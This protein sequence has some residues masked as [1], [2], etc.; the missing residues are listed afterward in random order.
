MFCTA[1]L[2]AGV[3]AGAS[4]EYLVDTGAPLGPF[5]Y[6]VGT[7]QSIGQ[8]FE[9]SLG[10]QIDSVEIFVRT[11][12][13]SLV[14][15]DLTI[16]LYAGDPV[17]TALFEETIDF[18]TTGGWIGANGLSWDVA[19]GPYTVTFGSS[20]DINN[21]GAGYPTAFNIPLWFANPGSADFVSGVGEASFSLRIGGEY[22]TAIPE[23]ETYALMLIGLA[24]VG[25]T[26]RR[27]G[28]R[29]S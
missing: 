5:G 29:A 18:A 23:P 9:T 10:A 28:A 26:A 2:A 4:A 7:V 6:S 21:I 14:S 16:S 8:S 24:A 19:A 13:G 11:T 20:N 1:V 3:S 27:R 22:V 17:G 12:A 15:S 25:A